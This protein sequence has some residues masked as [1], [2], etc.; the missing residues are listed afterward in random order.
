MSSPPAPEELAR[1]ADEQKEADLR[2]LAR[3]TARDAGGLTSLY[4]RHAALL[5]GLLIHIAGRA[6]AE[7][8]LEKVFARIWDRADVYDAALGSPRAW[9]VG[10]ARHH[11]FDWLRSHG[12]AG[13]R[14]GL[15]D[16]PEA[17]GERRAAA[18]LHSLATEERTLIEYAFFR[19][20][21]HGQLAEHFGLPVDTVK[22]R[23]RHGMHML[24]EML[25]KLSP[26]TRRES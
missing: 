3:I 8:L 16:W 20:L 13:D 5:F 24:I 17:A 1:R 19:G 11:A 2:D 18:V 22:A 25:A 4:D 6:A 15:Q 21:S 9:L 12:D 26:G 14:A 23:L 10:L 7:G